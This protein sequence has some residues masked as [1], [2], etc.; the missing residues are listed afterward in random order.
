M[1]TV[2][3]LNEDAAGSTPVNLQKDGCVHIVLYKSTV[4]I[5]HV[6]NLLPGMQTELGRITVGPWGLKLEAVCETLTIIPDHSHAEMGTL[7]CESTDVAKYELSPRSEERSEI[8]ILRHDDVIR[9][10]KSASSVVCKWTASE[11]Q[12]NSSAAEM[13]VTTEPTS[14]GNAASPEEE[15]DDEGLNEAT[16]IATVAHQPKATPTPHLSHQR[17]VIVQETPTADR[18]VGVTEFSKTMATKQDETISLGHADSSAVADSVEDEEDADTYST[19]HT[20]TAQSGDAQ[21]VTIIG[22]LE[23]TT[24]PVLAIKS[25]TDAVLSPAR[26][27]PRVRIPQ[28]LSRKRRSPTPNDNDLERGQADEVQ[29]NKRT[30]RDAEDQDDTQDSRMSAIDVHVPKEP[31]P[32]VVAKG[33]K[34]KSEIDQAPV[35]APSRSQRS[36]QRSTTAVADSRSYGGPIPQVAV[37]KSSIGKANHAVKFL[38]KQGG[39][40]V[41]S[42]EEPFNVLC[43]RDGE[44][45]KTPKLLLS[46]ARGIPIVTD[47]WLMDSAKA[48]HFLDTNAYIPSA[49]KQEKEWDIQLDRVIGRPQTPFEGYT[50]HFT[51]AVKDTY[52]AFTEIETVCKAAGAKKTIASTARLSKDGM[53]IVIAI[54]DGDAELEKLLQ[55]GVTCYYK[56]LIPQSILRGVLDLDSAEFKIEVDTAPKE[57]TKNKRQKSK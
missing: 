40:F 5:V 32:V 21:S 23:N 30:K 57:K 47:K 26:T 4:G 53:S 27:S 55:D 34:R 25:A 51:K 50:I 35:E 19:A 41:E 11:V 24:E 46:I 14:I 44:L 52:G 10:P 31:R 45:A 33:R 17:S 16:E 28:R 1:W 48:G 42:A 9:F 49:P 20:R 54:N 12:V 39:S 7:A 38:K 13:K 22:Q 2:T 3:A 36:S 6:P 37:S 8:L 29:S 15:T 18:V 56:D 43:I